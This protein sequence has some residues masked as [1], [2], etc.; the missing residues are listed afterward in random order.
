MLSGLTDDVKKGIGLGIGIIIATY[1]VGL[2]TG[3]FKKVF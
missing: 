2:A 1:I 3:V